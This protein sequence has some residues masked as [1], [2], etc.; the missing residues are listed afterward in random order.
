MTDDGRLL[1][2]WKR[3]GSQAAFAALVTRHLNFVYSVCLRETQN[4][5]LAEDVTQVV[6]LLLFRKAPSFGP[7]TRLTG[8]LF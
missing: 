6:F 8:W 4:A 3:Q 2:Q 5:V 7:D 1:E